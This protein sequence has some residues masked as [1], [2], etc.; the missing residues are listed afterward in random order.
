[1]PAW[2]IAAC[3]GISMALYTAG[4]ITNDCFDIEEDRRDRPSRPLPSGAV[5]KRSAWAVAAALILGALAGAFVVGRATVMVAA[6]LA[7]SVFLYNGLLKRVKLFRSVLTDFLRR[8]SAFLFPARKQFL[9][10]GGFRHTRRTHIESIGMNLL[11][12]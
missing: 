1:M 12:L 11:D 7:L 5:S 9:D 8:R 10:R 6:A 4:I 3:A 2:K